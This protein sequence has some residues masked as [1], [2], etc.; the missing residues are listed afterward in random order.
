M[1]GEE[2]Q[3]PPPNRSIT[4]EESTLAGEAVGRDDGAANA[5]TGVSMIIFSKSKLGMMRPFSL[6]PQHNIYIG[7]TWKN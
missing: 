5:S 6:N 2:Q 1:N 3:Y 4:P 7:K